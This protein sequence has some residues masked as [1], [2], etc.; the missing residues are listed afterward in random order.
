MKLTLAEA[1]PL[2]HA[3]V[4]E[5]SAL[6]GVRALVIKGLTL[7]WHGLR[8]AWIPA[9]VD[10]L[11][12]PSGVETFIAE[13]AKT[14]WRRRLGE[15]NDFP[16]PHHSV[17]LVHDEW[18]CDI[19][20][21]RRFAGFMADPDHVFDILWERHESMPVA[22]HAVPVADWASSVL[23]LALHSARITPDNP[24]H[25]AELVHLEELAQRWSDAQR[26][27]IATLAAQTGAAAALEAVLPRPG[28]EVVVDDELVDAEAHRQWQ[29]RVQGRTSSAGTWFGH[30]MSQ[31]V[32]RW[33]AAIRDALWPGEEFLRAGRPIP[34]GRK[35]LN[36][37]RSMRLANG[38][39]SVP[40]AL[41]KGAGI[42]RKNVIREASSA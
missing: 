11:L 6:A 24:R 16:V 2:V 10:V 15:F 40:G 41:L 21:H 3:S 31:P 22:G 19:G 36:R 14:G 8:P 7:E 26:A 9:D 38:L 1:I 35:A 42:R 27:D 12:A 28:V 32:R 17:T 25:V 18:P 33:P 29:L 39:F 5:A 37:A 30:L 4:G 13:M 20:V 34:P 23:I